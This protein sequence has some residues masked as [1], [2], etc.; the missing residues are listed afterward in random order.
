[1]NGPDLLQENQDKLRP[2]LGT[3]LAGC[4]VEHSESGPSF[5]ASGTLRE[6]RLTPQWR[7]ESI[8]GPVPEGMLEVHADWH[9]GQ[10]FI[11]DQALAYSSVHIDQNGIRVYP[12][13]A[14]GNT[15]VIH[16]TEEKP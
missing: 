9:G 5:E 4:R 1:M 16:L 11:P 10:V 15:W 7:V 13:F 3:T 12:R 14:G 6:L 2:F 8:G